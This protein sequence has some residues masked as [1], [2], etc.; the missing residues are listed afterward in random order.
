MAG[1]DLP[2][3][4]EKGTAQACCGAVDDFGSGT[5]IDVVT[6]RVSVCLAYSPVI[7]PHCTGIKKVIGPPIFIVPLPFLTLSL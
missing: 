1:C 5:L 6:C 4:G 7:I 2:Y 3:G